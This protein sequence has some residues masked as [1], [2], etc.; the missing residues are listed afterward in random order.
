MT[1][2]SNLP[3]E[4]KY[5]IMKNFNISTDLLNLGITDNENYGLYNRYIEDIKRRPK[6]ET[7]TSSMLTYREFFSL[8]WFNKFPD[9]VE[10]INI[11]PKKGIFTN[12]EISVI[13]NFSKRTD[14]SYVLL[15]NIK[16]ILN[17]VYTG[18]FETY[19]LN[20]I[21]LIT[22]NECTIDGVFNRDVIDGMA[23]YDIY[24]KLLFTNDNED[25]HFIYDILY[26][27]G[28]KKEYTQYDVNKGKVISKYT[29]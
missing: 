7:F 12:V 26:N 6:T 25:T 17:F 21:T 5:E 9:L 15:G 14:G 16:L 22:K 20:N 3:N 24:S 11:F 29:Y 4:I 1:S 10:L 18:T 19:D 13:G 2:Y 28:S 23:K 27:N 8:P